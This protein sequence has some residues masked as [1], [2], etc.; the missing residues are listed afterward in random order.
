MKVKR[1]ALAGLIAAA[2]LPVTGCGSQ[3]EAPAN[4]PAATSGSAGGLR[5]TGAAGATTGAA[6]G[7]AS[8]LGGSGRTLP[9]PPG[10]Q[11]GGK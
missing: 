1:L 9:P 2:V 10:F 6:T 8:P 7:A 3:E 5:P 4:A 11:P